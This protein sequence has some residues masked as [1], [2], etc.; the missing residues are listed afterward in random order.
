[1][2]RNWMLIL[3]DVK[4]RSRNRLGIAQLLDCICIVLEELH[5][6]FGILDF[7]T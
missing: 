5:A 2:S 7:L 1:M 4:L 6:L 3:Q